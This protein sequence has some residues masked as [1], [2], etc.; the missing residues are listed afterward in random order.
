[1]CWFNCFVHI[2]HERMDDNNRWLGRC[3]D[4]I[5]KLRPK[6]VE[7]KEILMLNF[8]VVKLKY[9]YST[10]PKFKSNVEPNRVRF[11]PHISTALQIEILNNWSRLSNYPVRF[12]FTCILIGGMTL[13]FTMYLL[14]FFFLWLIAFIEHILKCCA[15][16]TDVSGALC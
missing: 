5:H 3:L 6:S 8:F 11:F 1:M 13:R 14:G 12:I 9:G 16:L 10:F 7:E 15:I 4:C 2:L